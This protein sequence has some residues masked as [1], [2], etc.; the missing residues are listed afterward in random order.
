[1]RACLL[2]GEGLH[3]DVRRAAK[4]MDQRKPVPKR[5]RVSPICKVIYAIVCVG[6][7][8]LIIAVSLDIPETGRP[9]SEDR[10][11]VRC[12]PDQCTD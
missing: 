12:L 2:E 8:S 5:R 6:S 3:E 1:M 7:L 4:T 10:E 9:R 11:T